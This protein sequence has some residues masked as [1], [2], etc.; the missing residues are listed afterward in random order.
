MPCTRCS[1]DF[2]A[3]LAANDGYLAVLSPSS[4]DVTVCTASAAASPVLLVGWQ[5]PVCAVIPGLAVGA[6]SVSLS[7]LER[8]G[9]GPMS[10]AVGIPNAAPVVVS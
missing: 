8:S 3:R 7:L 5:S 2:G 4:G 1:Q 6:T 10:L 9:T